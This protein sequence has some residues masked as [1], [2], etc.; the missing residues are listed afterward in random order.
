MKSIGSYL[1]SRLFIGVTLVMAFG[2]LTLAIAMRSLDLREF[3]AAL[4]TKA[5][6]LS[7]LIFQHEKA[8]EIDFADEYLPEFERAEN[9]E[10]FQVSLIDGVIVER[11][12][13][14]GTNTLPVITDQDE[15]AVFRNLILP[16][17]RRGR[18]VQIAVL[19]RTDERAVDADEPDI[20]PLPELSQQDPRVLL[21]VAWGRQQLDTILWTIYCILLGMMLVLIALL[22]ILVH[23]F[24]RRGFKP[25]EAMN[26]Q[27]RELG[28]DALDRR[29][30]LSD[31]PVELQPVL[32]TLNGFLVDLQKAFDR[33]QRF[34]S[35][36][37]HELRTPVAEFR[38]ACEVG[39]T[40]PDDPELVRKRFAE[41]KESA[42]NME[43]KVAGL[44]E[45]S[46]LES[47][48]TSI[49][50]TAIQ[51]HA[52]I[53]SCWDQ[54][55]ASHNPSRLS[56][57]NQV[58]REFVL[59]SDEIKLQM[60]LQNLMY[61]ALNYSNPDTSVDV[62]ARRNNDHSFVLTISNTTD[63]LQQEDMEHLFER[64]W[65]KDP[66]RTGSQRMGLGLSIVKLLAERLDVRI[67]VELES[68]KR[69]L[70]HLRFP[71]SAN[72]E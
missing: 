62:V 47:Q 41:L 33:E 55:S 21:A 69:L 24:L 68:S 5:R 42:L 27:I 34:T 17:G 48:S 28:P 72:A 60:I 63:Q 56:L 8:I 53:Q 25:I 58:P 32:S 19:P 3:D 43:R 13:R 61:N 6:T 11:S 50:R 15:P 18:V 36:V 57:T 9:P 4:E 14:L 49:H 65:R 29:V 71:P 44:L 39:A 51:L 59:Y 40:W 22:M 30:R 16:D 70:I 26:A 7:T 38:I 66:A 54:T 23:R 1:K 37:A 52:F 12:D 67:N 20:I 2:S 35:N 64:F 10:Y 45:L 46:R 31:P